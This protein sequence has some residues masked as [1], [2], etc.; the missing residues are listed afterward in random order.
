MW[1]RRFLDAPD[2]VEKEK[3]TEKV[4]IA[5][6]EVSVKVEPIVETE[7]R[8][9][10]IELEPLPSLGVEI[11]ADIKNVGEETPVKKKRGFAKKIKAEEPLTSNNDAKDE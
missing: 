9:G 5:P 3:S 6:V 4:V 7:I 2:A 10:L 11:E 1:D 8:V